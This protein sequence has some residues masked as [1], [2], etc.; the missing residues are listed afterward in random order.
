MMKTKFTILSLL[1]SP[2]NS[3]VSLAE[4]LVVCFSSDCARSSYLGDTCDKAV[5]KGGSGTYL[6][7]ESS[8]G[9]KYIVCVN[10][11]GV[12]KNFQVYITEDGGY[13]FSGQTYPDLQRLVTFLQKHGITK[14]GRS[15]TLGRVAQ[16]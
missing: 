8:S 14:N 13:K 10:W 2:E 1:G 3:I 11:E 15:L 9:D 7:R 12:A 6:I 5:L 4:R 16:W